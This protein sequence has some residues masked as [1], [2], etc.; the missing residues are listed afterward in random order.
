DIHEN[1]VEVIRAALSTASTADDLLDCARAAAGTGD[2]VL[3]EE[4]AIRIGAEVE[5]ALAASSS[6]QVEAMYNKLDA[7]RGSGHKATVLGEAWGYVGRPLI[8]NRPH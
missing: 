5:D 4:V 6:W 8:E 1:L 3:M 2:P 7:W